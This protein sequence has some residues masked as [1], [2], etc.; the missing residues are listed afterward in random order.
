MILEWHGLYDYNESMVKKLVMAKSGNYMISVG[1]KEGGYRSI[2]VGKAV[3][4]EVRL[5]E[6]LSSNETNECLSNRVGEKALYFRYCYVDS[7][8]DRNNVEYTL[9][10][11]YSP[12][13]NKQEPSGKQMSI[14]LPY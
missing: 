3:N 7:E 5:L 6:H 10:K 1:L 4:L 14:T 2:Y 11:K 9:Y 13:C 8:E 12:S